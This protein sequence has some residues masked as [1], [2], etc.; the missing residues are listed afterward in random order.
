MDVNGY[1]KKV[2]LASGERI[3]TFDATAYHQ[4]KHAKVC[5]RDHSDRG[6]DFLCVSRAPYRPGFE[7]WNNQNKLTAHDLTK[8]AARDRESRP[9]IPRKHVQERGVSR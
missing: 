3:L 6:P 1:I 5:E 4:K 2:E 8:I 9:H 7:L